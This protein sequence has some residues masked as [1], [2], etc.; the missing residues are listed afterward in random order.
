VTKHDRPQPSS[1]ARANKVE[2]RLN[3][4]VHI[5]LYSDVAPGAPNR[6]RAAVSSAIA[7][8]LMAWR[9]CARPASLELIDGWEEEN[10][11]P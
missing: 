11:D 7:A 1:N 2:G 8:L 6:R 4:V 3:E 5:L 10:D 9:S